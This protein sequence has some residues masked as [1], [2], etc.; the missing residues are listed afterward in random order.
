MIPYGSIPGTW[1][2]RWFWKVELRYGDWWWDTPL[3][4]MRR[5]MRMNSWRRVL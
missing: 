4:V 1:Y 2:R 3:P 5:E